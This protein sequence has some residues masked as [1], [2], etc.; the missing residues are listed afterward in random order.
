MLDAKN[1]RGASG[2]ELTESQ[3]NASPSRGLLQCLALCYI[4]VALLWIVSL[5][6]PRLN[7][8]WFGMATLL[9]AIPAMLTLWHQDTV[10][11]LLEL[12]QFR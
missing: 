5:Q 7:V 3:E 9:L 2:A 10:R 12:H 11:R 6:V 8:L 4:F 1:D